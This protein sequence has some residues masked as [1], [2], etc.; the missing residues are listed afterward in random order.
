M[1][2][3]LITGAS[4]GIGAGLAE[5]YAAPD[6]ILHLLARRLDRLENVAH[7]CRAKGAHVFIHE[8]DVQNRDGMAH[9]LTGLDK[10]TPFDVVFANAGISGGT[11]GAG[12]TDIYTQDNAIF[13]VNL[14]GVLN[15]LHPILPQMT[16]RRSGQ[17]AIISSLAGYLPLPAAAAYT[18]SKAAVRYY[19]QALG[20]GLQKD[21]IY[22]SVV[23]SG[24]IKSEMTDTNDF[25]MPFFMPTEEAVKKIAKGLTQR[26]PNII[27]PQPLYIAI[28]TLSILP[29]HLLNCILKKLPAKKALPNS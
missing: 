16:E 8:M 3:I 5:H 7:L 12:D 15:T 11:G 4:S 24:F 9:L 6:V 2:T 1:L 14:G 28:L 13:A 17:I 21:N 22:V 26:K 23:C 19:G 10:V 20:V 29:K 25:Y 27:F 18:A